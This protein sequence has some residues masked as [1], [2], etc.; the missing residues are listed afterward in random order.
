MEGYRYADSHEAVAKI[1]TPRP[2]GAQLRGD[3]LVRVSK[4]MSALLRHDKKGG[5][6]R[7]DGWVSLDILLRIMHKRRNDVLAVVLENNK[8]R[9]SVGV[10][11]KTGIEYV[12]ANQG[13]SI[14][15]EVDMV[16]IVDPTTVA[17][18]GT[19][20]GAWKTIEQAG[21][22][23][24]K[25][26]HIHMASGLPGEV[27]SGMRNT[28]KVVIEID[29]AAAMADGIEFFRS[30]NDVVLSPGNAEGIIPPKYF[31]SV[32]HLP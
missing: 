10:G 32:K 21:L 24:M 17:L 8:Q 14:P 7:R 11:A 27:I 31:K 22:S 30:D 5:L 25:R 6:L 26:Q 16:R 4:R 12:R 28:A 13:H 29:V 1:E 23:R 9:F 2:D 19:N 20:R 18:H 3:D 15:V